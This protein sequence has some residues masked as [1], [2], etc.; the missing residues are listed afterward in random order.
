[1]KEGAAMSAVNYEVRENVGYV[2]LDNPPVNIMTQALMDA[3]AAV[4]ATAATDG[5]LKAIAITGEGKAFSAGADVGEHKPEQAPGMIESF[6]RLFRNLDALEIPVVMAVNGTAMGAGFELALMADV[7]LAAES[8]TFG[9]PEIR[10]GFFAPIGVVELPALVGRA[11]AMEITCS[12]RI[13]GAD[14]MKTCGLVSHVVPDG[15]LAEAVEATLK[16]FRRASALV[17]RLNVRNLKRLRGCPFV[18]AL[19]EA[20]NSFL[21]ELMVAEDPR[22]GIAAF[23]EKRRPEWKNR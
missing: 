1:M 9:Q 10:L 17:M 22:E 6:G 21:G 14:E 12:G 13:Y 15:E 7:L 18:E 3:L 16:D 2:T 5:D 8:A 19:E 23:Y 11:K 20:E 4:L